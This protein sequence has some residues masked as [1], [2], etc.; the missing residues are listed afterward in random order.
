MIRSLLKQI[1]DRVK[2]EKEAEFLS[3]CKTFNYEKINRYALAGGNINAVNKHDINGLALACFKTKDF[4]SESAAMKTVRTL[5][6]YGADPNHQDEDGYTALHWIC[7]SSQMFKIQ[8]LCERIALTLLDAGADV[9]IK[10][11]GGIT[12]LDF[13][14]MP[15]RKKLLAACR[16]IRKKNIVAQADVRNS[17][18]CDYQWEI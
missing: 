14:P 8:E 10:N 17:E 15:V 4:P 1:D 9:K 11:K 18:V 2:K 5:L 6:K 16:E 7:G 12:P 3:A 13:A